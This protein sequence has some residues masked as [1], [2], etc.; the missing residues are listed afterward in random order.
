MAA[1]AAVS[2]DQHLALQVT[3]QLCHVPIRAVVGEDPERGKAS[4]RPYKVQG[5]RKSVQSSEDEF[6]GRTKAAYPTPVLFSLSWT[7]DRS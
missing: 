7:Q 1:A 4:G 6:A 5:T 3:G 2:A